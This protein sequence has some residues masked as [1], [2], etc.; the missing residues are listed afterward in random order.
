MQHKVWVSGEEQQVWE[1]G[2]AVSLNAQHHSVCSGARCISFGGWSSALAFRDHLQQHLSEVTCFHMAVTELARESSRLKITMQI[3]PQNS[4]WVKCNPNCYHCQENAVWSHSQGQHL[5]QISSGALSQYDLKVSL[6]T[7]LNTA[8]P[9][10]HLNWKGLIPLR[11]HLQYKKI[12]I[13][14]RNLHINLGQYNDLHN[15]SQPQSFFC[16]WVWV[17]FHIFT[18]FNREHS[19]SWP[20]QAHHLADAQLA[21][22]KKPTGSRF[23]H[24]SPKSP[25]AVY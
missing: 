16:I 2:R 14:A 4:I 3:K 1:P 13:A 11:A 20:F 24:K 18:Y 6:W 9:S 22:S 8:F 23:L 10:Y 21:L 12:L 19:W 5:S 25:Y 15:R 7:A 17:F